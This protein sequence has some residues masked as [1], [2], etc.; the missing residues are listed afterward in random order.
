[1]RTSA[2]EDTCVGDGARAGMGGCARKGDGAH[3][4]ME[5][6]VRALAGK[7]GRAHV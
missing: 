3:V 4:G 6:H 5:G 7:I 1:M 2:R